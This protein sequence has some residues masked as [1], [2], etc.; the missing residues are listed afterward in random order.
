MKVR[1]TEAFYSV[2]GEGRWTGVPSVFLRMYGCNFTCPKF[3]IARDSNETA[4][5]HINKIVD[6]IDKYNS[7]DEL[8]L[9]TV[10]CDSYA[11]WHPAFKRFQHDVDIDQLVDDLL[12]LTPTGSWT[13]DNGQDIHLVIT[14]G[15][16]LL[17]W[18][19]AYIQLF[20]HER[21]KDLKNVT[22]ETNTTQN[23]SDDLRSY[24]TDNQHVHITFSCSP[25]L[26]VSGHTW[27]DAIKPDVAVKYASVPNSHLYLKFVVC[28]DVDVAEVDRAV[29]EYRSA[30]LEA[31]VYLMPVGG[32]TDSYFKNG[33]QVAELALEKGYRY[34]PRLHVDVFGNAWG[35]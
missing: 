13:L 18:Q 33:R 29:A 9:V 3:G 17:G 30:G 16:P 34:S 4:E 27:V 15:E 14:G 26:S 28:D 2:Q 10:G 12:A 31:P 20:K 25:K 19:R 8:P 24:L 11:A 5:P 35:T 32:T 23:L 6:E 7:I 1:Y 22:F 21:M